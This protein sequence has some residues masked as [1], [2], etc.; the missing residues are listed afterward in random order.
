MRN[1]ALNL[2]EHKD[3]RVITKKLKKT[4]SESEIYRLQICVMQRVILRNTAS[5]DCVSPLIARL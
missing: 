3:L 4:E 2:R 5:V 1:I